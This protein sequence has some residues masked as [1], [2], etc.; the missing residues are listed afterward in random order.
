MYA[1]FYCQ[2]V[3]LL[4]SYFINRNL[5]IELLYYQFKQIK[6]AVSNMVKIIGFKCGYFLQTHAVQHT[7]EKPYQCLHCPRT[8]ASSG[9]FHKHKKRMHSAE[10]LCNLT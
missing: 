7:G 1:L 4:A 3:I 9:N 6:H 8:F 10:R 5:R 2:T